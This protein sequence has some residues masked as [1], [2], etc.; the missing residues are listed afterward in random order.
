MGACLTICFGL[1]TSEQIR[2]ATQPKYKVA[3]YYFIGATF[4]IGI[5]HLAESL[6]L[7]FQY[8]SLEMFSMLVLILAS[9]QALMFTFLLILLFNSRYV[10]SGRIVRHAAPSLL[11][12]LAY[13]I[14]CYIEPDISV[15]SFN[16]WGEQI[17]HNLPLTVRTLFGVTY[18]IQLLVYTHLF[19]RK[20]HHYTTQIKQLSNQHKSQ[21]E[22]RWTT[23]AF[24]YA[25]GIGV[26][27]LILLVYP[28]AVPELTFSF[29]IVIFYLSFAWL[30][31]KFHYTYELLR[32]LIIKQDE[33]LPKPPPEADMEEL[34]CYLQPIM[35]N[36]LFEE[37]EAYLK[38][39]RPHLDANC[40]RTD[41]YKA[42]G[43]N[44]RNLSTAVG[45]ATGLTV[46]NYLLR[47]RIRHAM[48]LLLLP[49]NTNHTIED[50]AY[51]SGFTSISTFNRNFRE[52]LKKTPSEFRQQRPIP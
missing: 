45:R 9:S 14:S 11:F 26:G 47:L 15:H 42:L 50:I 35:N 41:L 43:T 28:G 36:R 49:D 44:E 2:N 21:L 29:L 31:T 37:L 48:E 18:F 32:N 23:R 25:L 20:Q 33:Q 39:E 3:C 10:T 40:T 17:F 4:L 16:V 8:Q 1:F 52:L 5:G 22:L 7:D 27:A 30:Y 51:A 34:I 6:M 12:I 46:Q 19:F 38:T 13:I 24:L